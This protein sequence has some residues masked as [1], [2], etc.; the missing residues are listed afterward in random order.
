MRLFL[1]DLVLFP[2]IAVGGV[3]ILFLRILG[4]FLMIGGLLTFPFWF[5][6]DLA[7]VGAQILA[8]VFAG[9]TLLAVANRF[10]R[11]R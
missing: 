10:T 3:V 11:T 6:G 4:G 2:V 1:K 5:T 8:A 7:G 9:S